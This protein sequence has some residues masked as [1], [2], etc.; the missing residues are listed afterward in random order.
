MMGCGMMKG[1]MKGSC[2]MNNGGNCGMEGCGCN[3][4]VGTITTGQ[5]IGMTGVN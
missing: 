2:G 3:K 5:I 4:Q 1:D